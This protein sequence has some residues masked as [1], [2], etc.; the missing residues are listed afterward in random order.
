MGESIRKSRGFR[1]ALDDALEDRTVPS[2]LLGGFG[3]S[4]VLGIIGDFASRG[5]QLLD[6][7]FG[8]GAGLGLRGGRDLGGLSRP[9]GVGASAS[10][11]KQDARLVT[12]AFQTFNASYSAAVAALRQT[13]TTT[14]GPTQAGLGAY[15]KAVA[16]AISNL[17]S[18]IS[19][20]LSNL[21]TSGSGLIA[22]IDGYTST[23][24]TELQS[25]GSGLANST[26]QAVLALRHEARLDIREAQG[27]SDSAI[28]NV[29]PAG[30]ITGTTLQTYQQ[31]VRTAYQSFQ[32]AISNAEQAAIAGGTQLSSTAVSSAVSALQTAL[33]SAINGLGTAFASSTYNP[34]ATV[35]TQLSSLQSQ[36]LAIAAPTAGNTVSERLFLRTVSSV[37]DQSQGAINQAV[38]TAIQNYNNSLL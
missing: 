16:T 20:D 35:T 1:P 30:S 17:N 2:H 18:A 36:L 25:A 12:Q 27:Q 33:T 13:A 31:A 29:Q 15:N 6:G 3:R 32:L 21:S 37:V 24:Q 26:N 19:S 34:T 5:G 14:S 7:A 8:R 38:A 4:G 11:L 10:T 22:T 9:R 23:L 28:L